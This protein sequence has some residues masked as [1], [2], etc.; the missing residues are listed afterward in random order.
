MDVKNLCLVSKKYVRLFVFM[1]LFLMS[2]SGIYASWYNDNW[3]SRKSIIINST[4]VIGEHNDFPILVD[5]T[6][7]DLAN[8]AKSDGSDI[9]F[10][11]SD[12]TTLLD[13][14]IERY[15]SSTG[16]LIS[17]VEVSSLNSSA[18]GEIYMYYGNSGATSLSDSAGVWD[19][20]E[21]VY[22][23]DQ[24]DFGSGSTVDSKN[25]FA[26][27]PENM[28]PSNVV[29]GKIGKALDFDGTTNR[30]VLGDID[31]TG[32]ESTISAWVN[33][34]SG[35]IP[36]V[37]L[38]KSVFETH[39]NPFFA[40]AFYISSDIIQG[41]HGTH[42]PQGPNSYV[43][44]WT[45][46][47]ATMD[48]TNVIVY[49]NG[50]ELDSAPITDDHRV[51]D[52]NAVIGGRDTPTTG[53]AEFFNGQIDEVRISNIS[54]SADYILTSYNNQ[55]SPDA[56]LSVSSEERASIEGPTITLAGTSG[57]SKV[58]EGN[59]S[60]SIWVQVAD[61]DTCAFS[62]TE[63]EDFN[64]KIVMGAVSS[65]S[66]SQQVYL[67]DGVHTY[68]ISC[69][70]SFGNIGNEFNLNVT[71]DATSPII[72]SL[73]PADTNKINTD[74]VTVTFE[75]TDSNLDNVTIKFN[76]GE[77]QIVTGSSGSYTHTESNLNEGSN[78]YTI[79][80]FD[81]FGNSNVTI[82]S[83]LVDT[84]KPAINTVVP[85]NQS[86]VTADT[87]TIS[88]DVTDN[89]LSSVTLNFNG[90]DVTT[91]NNGDT[92][93]YTAS[94]LTDGDYNFTI[95]AVDGSSNQEVQFMVFTVDIPDTS[96]P[97]TTK[98]TIDITSPEDGAIITAESTIINFTASDDVALS[99]V[100]IDF[101]S[102]GYVS[103]T[104]LGNGNYEY[105]ATN[106]VNGITYNYT[107]KAVDTSDNQANNTRSF[108]VNITEIS[109]PE[110]TE[111]PKVN[112]TSPI[113]G[114]IITAE[115]ITI[116]F[117]AS[118][119][120]ALSSVEI[121]FNSTGYVSATDL[122]DGEYS[123]E[124]TGLIDGDYNYTVKAVDTSNREATATR[125]F[126]V[127][128]PDT[129]DP[130]TEDPT[131][132]IVSP[133]NGT[134]ITEDSVNISFTVND[135]EGLNSV[136]I[137][138][139]SAGYVSATDLGDGEYIY[140]ATNL[141][142]GITYNYT[143]KA[144]DTSDNDVEATGTFIVD[145]PDTTDPTITDIQPENGTT[146]EEDSVTI[147][148]KANDETD[149]KSVNLNFA[150]LDVILTKTGDDYSYQ[151]TNL[152]DGTTYSYTITAVD[153][154]DNDV[155]VTRTFIVDIPDTTNPTVN[156][157]S[158]EDGA[159][160]TSGS[161]VI[162]FTAS[163]DVALDSVSITFDGVEIPL[164]VSGTSYS[165]EATGL[166]DGRTYTYT[167]RAVDT[168]NNPAEDTG[169]FKV[170]LP[171]T[172]NPVISSASPLNG[173]I[174]TTDSTTI[175]FKVTDS[176]DDLVSVVLSVGGE[177]INLSNLTSPYSYSVSGLT[178]GDHTYTITATDNQS[179]QATLS[180]TFTVETST[181]D[182]EDDDNGG[183]SSSSS[184]GGSSGSSKK[185]VDVSSDLRKNDNLEI[186][187][188]EYGSVNDRYRGEQTVSIKSKELGLNILEFDHDFSSDLD[189]EDLKISNGKT[190]NDKNYLI[191][192]GLE[193]EEGKTKTVR[194]ASQSNS[195]CIK[196][197]EV[198]SV[199]QVSEDC[200][201][202]NEYIL[203]CNG[204]V[205]SQGHSCKK[206]G[207]YLEISG[208]KHSAILE[209]D[210]VDES[211]VL[212]E[213]DIKEEVKESNYEK[214]L[215]QENTKVKV[216]NSNIVDDKELETETNGVESE[217]TNYLIP[218]I[219]F[220]II[221]VI[222]FFYLRKSDLLKKFN[223]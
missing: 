155:E 56:F 104:D 12:G 110:D 119:D 162:S 47:T 75:V 192:S 158:P 3:E 139:N 100:E 51:S 102:T 93:S 81:T 48:G 208:L 83:V 205:N 14:E 128:I 135:N 143:V 11:N 190:S 65:T 130:D 105:E 58:S 43:D 117:T 10:T 221:G 171:D 116:N 41:R 60:L 175:S 69:S 144:V 68:Y 166:E 4:M 40:W 33:F 215:S 21:A 140:E 118:D 59:T 180:N 84:S 170:D 54:H 49:A 55:N 114:A 64:S 82:A 32:R 121:N 74:S 179:A 213:N 37:A 28:D 142:D 129:K 219:I 20:Y 152:V 70:D 25:V 187:I 183:S 134:I 95:T 178:N 167:V 211:N 163:D 177:D 19:T 138:F 113:D 35:S 112:I 111:D 29:D 27:T 202:F 34:D 174:I 133:E 36:G 101:N 217:K 172:T 191:V 18:N 94:S 90:L 107:V 31:L 16:R 194:I 199:D 218:F 109:D 61:A 6:D 206:F 122:G 222:A 188:G 157:T 200:L 9:L 91:S 115:S 137:N 42:T 146:I 88:F 154:S 108:T 72:D 2:F 80:A 77:E 13:F 181:D 141:V 92:Y 79:T 207:D 86:T 46:V 186:T 125:S 96:D 8:A 223:K 182:D 169:S 1:T 87:T 131:I 17:W 165:Y 53:L 7:S 132:N 212:N 123:Y 150:G 198:D 57:E 62:T 159:N 39:S 168:S 78:S 124:A 30:I 203:V 147:S 71:T 98:P 204:S 148:F 76:S 38:S 23:L 89:D 99:S 173:E 44:Q 214:E 73:L 176:D 15:N 196:D 24:E 161:Q 193:L 195:V 103:A 184:G 210:A 164:S 149:L 22:H 216:D 67:L 209:F 26:G 66:A 63:G 189:L 5:M 45:H 145:I 126:T 120:V 106:L 197:Q 136:E 153:T 85:A 151:A 50:E 156:I 160:V 185:S 201:S 97:D 220:L 52:Q 127:E